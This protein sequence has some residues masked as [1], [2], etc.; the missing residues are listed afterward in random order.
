MQTSRLERS[1]ATVRKAPTTPAPEWEGLF[2]EPVYADGQ[3]YGAFTTE[4]RDAPADDF[5]S[6]AA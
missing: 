5:E 4:D 1:I 2:V 6:T 3:P